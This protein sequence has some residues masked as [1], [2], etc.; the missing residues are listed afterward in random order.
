MNK[1]VMLSINPKYCELIASGKKTIEVRRT[2]PKKLKTP[3]KCYIYKTSQKYKKGTGI[4]LYG[5]ELKGTAQ[6]RGKVIGEFICDNID[7]Y[8]YHK[9][10]TKFGGP[11]GLPIGTFASYLIFENDYKA[12]CLTYDE[13]QDYG[14][15]KTLYGWHISDLKIY[16]TPKELS[17]FY[18]TAYQKNCK[19]C[20]ALCEYYPNCELKKNRKPLK[21]PFLS[22]GYVEEV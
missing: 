7:T 12:M 8:N 21:R 2:R 19:P 1:A 17:E 20:D 5:V 4:Y 11:L 3:F 13:V 22:W 16:D 14:E 18:S 10:L 6:G 9:G 15:G